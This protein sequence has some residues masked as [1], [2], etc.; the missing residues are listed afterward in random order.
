MTDNN[1]NEHEDESKPL[2]EEVHLFL[3]TH[4]KTLQA[5]RRQDDFFVQEFLPKMEGKPL[6]D[7]LIELQHSIKLYMLKYKIKIFAGV[8]IND[9]G[10]KVHELHTEE[11]FK[12]LINL[13]K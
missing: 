2:F 4:S 8:L 7:Y 5:K 13:Y 1:T 12:N 11:D 3:H 9:S 10:C 6:I